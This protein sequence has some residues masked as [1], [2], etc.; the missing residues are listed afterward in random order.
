MEQSF[1]ENGF[2]QSS[3][4]AAAVPGEVDS[5]R[6]QAAEYRC[7]HLNSQTAAE[8]LT[9][10]QML[11]NQLRGNNKADLSPSRCVRAR[12]CECTR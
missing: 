9:D 11:D 3:V 2:T 10:S 6:E 12:V 1:G 7:Y 5:G 8:R 4:N